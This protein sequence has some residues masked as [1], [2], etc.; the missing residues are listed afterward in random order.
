MLVNVVAPP[1]QVGAVHSELRERLEE[2]MRERGYRLTIANNN[3]DVPAV[4]TAVNSSRVISDIRRDLLRV[5]GSFGPVNKWLTHLLFRTR[6]SRRLW[7]LSSRIR[8][9]A[10]PLTTWRKYRIRELLVPSTSLSTPLSVT[11]WT[12]TRWDESCISIESSKVK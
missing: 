8:E 11:F 7:S 10:A 4:V 6:L 9:A 1:P 12:V 2:H 3:P 5:R